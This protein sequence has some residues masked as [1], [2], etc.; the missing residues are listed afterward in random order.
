M[1]DVK[2]VLKR[3]VA[4]GLQVNPDKSNWTKDQIEYLGFLLTGNG[5]EPQLTK[6][7]GTLDVNTPQN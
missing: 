4:K 6:A 3:L 1:K 2:E 7:Q 5:V